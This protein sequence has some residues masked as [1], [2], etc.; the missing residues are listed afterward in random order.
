MQS[1]VGEEHHARDPRRL[2]LG[3]QRGCLVTD[4]CD[5]GRVEAEFLG[6]GGPAVLL[7]Q[8]LEPGEVEAG[9]GGVHQ[10]EGPRLRRQRLVARPLRLLARQRPSHE[11]RGQ[12]RVGVVVRAVVPAV[13]ALRGG[14]LRGRRRAGD[15][16]LARGD[17]RREH[18]RAAGPRGGHVDDHERLAVDHLE[19]VGALRGLIGTTRGD[20]LDVRLTPPQLIRPQLRLGEVVQLHV[21]GD[22]VGDLRRRTRRLVL[23]SGC[24][25]APGE[26]LVVRDVGD[27]LHFGGR[28]PWCGRPT[29]VLAFGPR[30]HTE[31]STADDVERRAAVRSAGCLRQRGGRP[32]P[33]PFGWGPVPFPSTSGVVAAAATEP[34]AQTRENAVS[35]A[36]KRLLTHHVRV[37]FPP[38]APAPRP[39][40]SMLVTRV[41]SR[42]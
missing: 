10:P 26:H 22:R 33:S 41:P 38:C 8:G 40:G 4:L 13:R 29:I 11:R 42:W 6:H 37:M 27:D 17:R 19:R 15:E 9:G 21:V 30:A 14:D 35:S 7:H 24:A 2:E 31:R 5:V 20:D 32:K 16:D 12:R 28:H 3:D 18:R 36:T 39:D 25:R 23:R 1:V 34:N